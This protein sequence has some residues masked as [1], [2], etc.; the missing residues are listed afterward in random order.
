MSISPGVTVAEIREFVHEYQ[1]VLHG[2]KGVGLAERE[3]S[4]STLGRWQSAVFDGDLDRGLIPREGSQMTVPPGK[5][6]A[7][8]KM[9]AAEREAH[10][11]EIAKLSGRVRELEET[12]TALG[13]AIGLLHAMSEEEPTHNPT[14]S[15]SLSAQSRMLTTRLSRPTSKR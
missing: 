11:A 2:Q 9:R 14:A 3:F 10:A 6:T 1:R 5:R 4:Y 7:L 12:N 13:K 15:S 8:E